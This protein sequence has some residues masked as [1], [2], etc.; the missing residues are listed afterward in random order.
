MMS[1][2]VIQLFD[3][4]IAPDVRL[5]KNTSSFTKQTLSCE[6]H[7]Y[8][9]KHTNGY[10]AAV[11]AIPMGMISVFNSLFFFLDGSGAVNR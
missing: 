3:A 9:Y 11:A 8:I 10:C 6:E 4:L 1:K 2:V 5:A 7:T